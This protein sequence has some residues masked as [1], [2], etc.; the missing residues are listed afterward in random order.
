MSGVTSYLVNVEDGRNNPTPFLVTGTTVNPM[1]VVNGLTGGFVYK[2]KVRSNCGGNHSSWSPWFTFVAGGGAINCNLLTGLSVS[3]I[4]STGSTF[5]W[6]PSPGGLGYRIKVEDGS[7]NPINYS[8]VANTL[9]NSYTIS[10]LTPSSNYKV[11]VRKL[12]AV[13][14]TGPWSAWMPFTTAAL[15]L[16][17][18]DDV[19]EALI[20]VHP[21]P[22]SQ[23]FQ[24]DVNSD[25]DE[26]IRK[27]ELYDLT[28]KMVASELVSDETTFKFPI[29]DFNN[30]VYVVKI[31]TNNNYISRRLIVLN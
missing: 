31:Q 14:V 28:G 25:S 4:T 26:K 11:K 24:L 27:V 23:Y 20:S 5:S 8:F 29:Q 19:E 21:N 10:G 30:G 7:G 3:N 15:R 22:A 2:F 16:T 18:S 6:N 17:G 1:F 13:G 9:L 12:C